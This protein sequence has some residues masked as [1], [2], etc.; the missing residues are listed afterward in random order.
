MCR[1][2]ARPRRIGPVRSSATR[3]EEHTSE[4]Q[5]P[6][7]LVCR[8]LLEKKNVAH[9]LARKF[10]RG[11]FKIAPEFVITFLAANK[12]NNCY[13]RRQLTIGCKVIQSVDEF[14]VRDIAR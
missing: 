11:F 5:S 3:S 6:D 7:Q 4:L 12:S 10:A 9:G 1:S 2:M 13:R 14:V 8:L